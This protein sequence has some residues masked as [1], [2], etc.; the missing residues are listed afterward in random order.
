M[1]RRE[2]EEAE[3]FPLL[4]LLDPLVSFSPK[5]AEGYG[6][7]AGRE[8]GDGKSQLIKGLVLLGPRGA[9]RTFHGTVL[10]NEAL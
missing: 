6:R 4:P 5:V 8:Q 9:V 1:G 10:G 7:T 3:T 2:W